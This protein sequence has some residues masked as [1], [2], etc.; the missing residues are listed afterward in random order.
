MSYNEAGERALSGRL[1]I[2]PHEARQT[3]NRSMRIA[4]KLLQRL[5]EQIRGEPGLRRVCFPR[6]GAPTAHPGSRAA[7]RKGRGRGGCDQDII[8]IEIAELKRLQ[9]SASGIDLAVHNGVEHKRCVTGAGCILPNNLNEQTG[10]IG[11][12][13][14]LRDTAW[15]KRIMLC[16]KVEER[17][18]NR[19]PNAKLIF[20][21]Q[22][23]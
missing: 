22:A 1:F 23:A 5:I 7:I 14:P 19:M 16:V 21:E 8:H 3:T 9:V 10:I 4:S 15:C 11:S 12:Q 20:A 6:K 13:H 17:N 18:G 2:L